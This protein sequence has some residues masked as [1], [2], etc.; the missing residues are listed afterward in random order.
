MESE[1]DATL[2]G[3]LKV[4]PRC[5]TPL[6]RPLSVVCWIIFWRLFFSATSTI[7]RYMPVAV[8]MT[9]SDLRETKEVDML[10]QQTCTQ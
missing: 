2:E 1:H 4:M 9:T 8:V 5:G 3:H 10:I 6:W 7:N